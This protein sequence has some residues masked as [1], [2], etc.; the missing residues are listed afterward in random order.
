MGVRHLT[1]LLETH[2]DI[3]ND[4]LFGDNRLVIDG[5]DL[6]EQLYFDSGRDP[7]VSGSVWGTRF[8][9]LSSRKVDK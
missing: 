5:C 4:A 6:I 1:A 3:Y 2:Q 9:P 8:R 7:A